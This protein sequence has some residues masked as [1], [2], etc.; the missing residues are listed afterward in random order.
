MFAAFK[1]WNFRLKIL[2]MQMHTKSW[3]ISNAMQ[4]AWPCKSWEFRRKIII[5]AG[6]NLIEWDN[7]VTDS[8]DI[9]QSWSFTRRSNQF[10]AI[11]NRLCRVRIII[12]KNIKIPFKFIKQT[13]GKRQKIENNWLA[14]QENNSFVQRYFL[15]NKLSFN[16]WICY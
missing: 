13:I 5:S 12:L 16:I 6:G 9:H 14:L 4:T 8:L 15:N 1:S 7:E 2:V 3:C 10:N 11:A